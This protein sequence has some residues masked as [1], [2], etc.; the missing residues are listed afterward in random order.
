VTTCESKFPYLFV[1]Y[2]QEFLSLQWEQEAVRFGGLFLLFFF[3]SLAGFLYFKGRLCKAFKRKNSTNLFPIFESINLTKQGK[4]IKHSRQHVP[5]M[6]R[7]L[8]ETA[9][10]HYFYASQTQLHKKINQDRDNFG[11]W[12]FP[13]IILN[14]LHSFYIILSILWTVIFH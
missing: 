7:G 13:C 11:G 1:H 3:L 5:S 14:I 10:T 4:N 9:S 6:E 12:L 2:N 8:K